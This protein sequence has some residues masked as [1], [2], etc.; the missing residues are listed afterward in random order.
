MKLDIDDYTSYNIRCLNTHLIDNKY[1]AHEYITLLL[2]RFIRPLEPFAPT[3]INVLDFRIYYCSDEY[4]LFK[5][6]ALSN[7]SPKHIWR[8]SY[9]IISSA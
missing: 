8:S 7:A 9:P 3:I 4:Y 2:I 6:K 1:H 5:S